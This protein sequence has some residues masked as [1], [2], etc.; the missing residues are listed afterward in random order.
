MDLWESFNETASSEKESFHSHLNMEFITDADCTD[1]KLVCK[2]FE[3]KQKHECYD[4]DNQINTFLPVDVFENFGSWNMY[5]R[6]VYVRTEYIY[7]N[8]ANDVETRF[9]IQIMNSTKHCLKVKKSYW[10]NKR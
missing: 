10:I 7:L 4:L 3:I 5:I 8:I 1:A 9:D 2:D 6:I